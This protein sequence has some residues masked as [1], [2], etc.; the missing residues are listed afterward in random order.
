MIRFLQSLTLRFGG[1]VWW[2]SY[3]L[4]R[5]ALLMITLALSIIFLMPNLY[6]GLGLPLTA[7]LA[8]VV[9]FWALV[10]KIIRD[11]D[12]DPAA[13][14][15]VSVLLVVASVLYI[16]PQVYGLE[17]ADQVEWLDQYGLGS[18]PGALSAANPDEGTVNVL[19][20]PIL[21]L[22]LVLFGVTA[23]FLFVRFLMRLGGPVEEVHGESLTGAAKR[24]PSRSA[25]VEDEATEQR[26]RRR[27]VAHDR[28]E[29]L[30]VDEAGRLAETAGQ[31]P[32]DDRGG[33]VSPSGGLGQSLPHGDLEL[34]HG[35]RA[36]E[37]GRQLGR[38]QPRPV[39][40]VASL[41]L[42]LE[43]ALDHQPDGLVLGH[44]TAVGLAGVDPDVDD[45]VDRRPQVELPVDQE[46]AGSS[47]P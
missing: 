26:D 2:L 19:A 25:F 40:L 17:A 34:P 6:I 24:A 39:V 44:R 37:V 28:L 21:E 47:E 10:V 4:M 42:L 15:L 23:A 27:G 5:D 18:V 46:G 16:V 33:R 3:V 31:C 29:M 7:P 36:D 22:S 32:F 13:I 35:H 43:T 8:A 41:G 30:P 20:W 45:R 11:A 12:D 14:R 1:D 38:R 9:L